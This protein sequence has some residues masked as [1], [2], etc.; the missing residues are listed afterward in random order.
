MRHPLGSVWRGVSL[1]HIVTLPTLP[2][3]TVLDKEGGGLMFFFTKLVRNLPVAY[4]FE[5]LYL[6]H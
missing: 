3:Y 1:E 2:T 6:L 5:N 4:V